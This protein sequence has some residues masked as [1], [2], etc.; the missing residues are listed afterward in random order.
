[1][2]TS[3][4][5]LMVDLPLLPHGFK[6]AADR[7]LLTVGTVTGYN[8]DR[9]EA[10]VAVGVGGEGTVLPVIADV[11]WSAVATLTRTC[12]V[13]RDPRD[14]R[15]QAA[16]A[17]VQTAPDLGEELPAGVGTVT[18][19]SGT[20]VTVL[21][22]D[23]VT[24]VATALA[25]YTSPAVGH[26]V[27]LLWSPDLSLAFIPAQY[28]GVAG[29]PPT[30]AGLSASRS[31]NVVTATWGEAV[32][33]TGY[34]VQTSFNNGAS[35]ST[36]AAPGTSRTFTMSQGQTVLVRVRAV[37]GNGASAWSP[38]V[39]VAWSPPAPPPPV[40]VTRTVT[41]T[42]HDSATFRHTRGAWDRWNTGSYGGASTLYQ[43]NEHGSG[44]LTGAAFYADRVT[45]LGAVSI[46]RIRVLL[47]GAGLN[48]STFPPVTVRGI[49][50]GSRPGGSPTGVGGDASG[51][52][53][54]AGTAWVTL[55]A[56]A[57][58]A[59]RT[60]GIRG[61]ATVGG[62]YAAVRGISAADGMALEIVYQVK[63]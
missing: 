42:P 49:A 9:R 43:G 63:Q 59:W 30:P 34:E 33:A 18:A 14:G 48:E 39:S 4:L 1:M 41:V 55:P 16:L 10:T 47:R 61:L 37:N 29:A 20:T 22:A 19:V 27:P 28:T 44:P 35:W 38:I 53:G 57:Y 26:R 13:L 7:S 31:G 3:D 50:E 2:T 60:G 52:P 17:P 36:M 5:Q 11:D 58:E 62:G 21:G 40:T 23:G 15:S 46:S 54:R 51:S 25:S 56:S 24:Y 45:R 6:P 12:W 8:A 32:T